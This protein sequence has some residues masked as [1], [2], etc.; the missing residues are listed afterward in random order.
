MKYPL[1]A[2]S[3]ATLISASLQS[4]DEKLAL[5]AVHYSSA[6]YCAYDIIDSW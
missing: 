5:A 1:L 3:V 6:A 2:V 4:Y